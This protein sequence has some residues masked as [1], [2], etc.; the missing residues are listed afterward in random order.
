MAQQS[1]PDWFASFLGCLEQGRAEEGLIRYLDDFLA[2]YAAI[3]AVTQPAGIEH[4][5]DMFGHQEL[6][7]RFEEFIDQLVIAN[8]NNYLLLFPAQMSKEEA[9]TRYRQLIRT[10]HP[11][12]G[13]K[14]EAW[15][16]FR[17][18]RINNAYDEYL[19]G[20]SANTVGHADPAQAIR[21]N[22]SNSKPLAP[23]PQHQPGQQK[24][25]R[26]AI[27]Y[28]KEKL[29]Q[30]LG[31][32]VV[33]QSRIIWWLTAIAIGVAVGFVGAQKWISNRSFDVSTAL[34]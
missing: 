8:P 6:R 22:P 26:W 19:S 24:K 2:W 13:E 10:F 20:N 21:V 9:K 5:L 7:V 29:R 15:L 25:P 14:N 32:P 34:Y 33:L 4:A 30:W 12:R 23:P 11:D 16:T 27:R 18:E 1:L 3:N 28:R 17:A 31:D